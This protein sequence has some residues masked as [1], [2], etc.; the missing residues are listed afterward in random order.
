M[1]RL[2]PLFSVVFVVGVALL[3]GGCLMSGTG[4]SPVFEPDAEHTAASRKHTGIPSIAAA[5]NG[6]IWL[7]YYGGPTGGEDSNNYC[8][9]ATSVDSGM[10]WCDVLIADP[11]GVGPKRAFDPE[12][13]VAPNGKLYWTWTE[14]VVPLQK[15]VENVNAGC[16]ADPKN[17]RLMG[18]VLEANELPTNRTPAPFEFCR[19]VMMCKPIVLDDGTWM[20]PSA[21]WSDAPSSCFYS[22]SDEGK[23]FV[24][25]GGVTL[26]E[27]KRT[28]DEHAVV[29]LSN[30][31]LL[32]LIRTVR[33][34][35]THQSISHDRGKTWEEPKPANFKHTDSR[36]FLRKLKSGNLLLVKHGAINKDVGRSELTA[37]IST[38]DGATWKGG[39]LI[40][41]R[42]G[43]SYPDGDQTR[44][45]AI[46]LVHD[47][48]R[49]GAQEILLSRFTE[50]DILAGKLVN[51]SSW[52][53][54]RIVSA[55]NK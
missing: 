39:L 30:G 2:D 23:S 26:P 7:T 48:D 21:H 31:D 43:A 52:L 18:V 1:K 17:D 3:T 28:Y 6:R 12:V 19:G 27:Q 5:P 29:Q 34:P 16:L 4:T 54:R 44:D 14:R 22:S 8:T 46:Y 55:E 35:K 41:E 24:M 9:L 51:S 47:H 40:D 50:E 42:K 20:W 49:C 15:D 13:W 37:F 45:G 33:G 36:L 25:R 38:D 32:T 53:A 11:D 10:T